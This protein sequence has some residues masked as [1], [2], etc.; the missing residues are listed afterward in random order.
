VCDFLI[1]SIRDHIEE[2]GVDVDY[3][4]TALREKLAD[5]SNICMKLHNVAGNINPR[6]SNQSVA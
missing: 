4:A 3:D 6:R 2:S 5:V 1:N